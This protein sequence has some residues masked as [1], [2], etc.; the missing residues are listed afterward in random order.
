MRLDTCL[1]C[2]VSSGTYYTA[3]YLGPTSMVSKAGPCPIAGHHLLPQAWSWNAVSILRRQSCEVLVTAGVMARL[4]FWLS[5]AEHSIWHLLD[6]LNKYRAPYF[7]QCGN[8]LP[9]LALL[10]PFLP[11][12][13]HTVPGH[14]LS[15]ISFCL[16]WFQFYTTDF[17]SVLTCGHNA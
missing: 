9:I 5:N 17:L 11:S 15:L 10:N 8:S 4:P 13:C 3:R 16:T 7:P 2:L 14:V 6:L 1:F 12:L